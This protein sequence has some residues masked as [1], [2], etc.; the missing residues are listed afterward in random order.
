MSVFIKICGL[1]HRDALNAAVQAGADAVGF[2][3]AKS[4]RRVTPD[5]A[6]ELARDLP[7]TIIR[8]AVMHH[9]TPEQWQEVA[10]IFQPDW[11][12]TDAEDLASL[13]ISASVRTVPVF[14]DRAKLDESVLAA[15]EFIV[16]EAAVS[17]Q[18]TRADWQRARKLAAR[19]S[20][21]LAGGLDPENV[22]EAIEKVNPWGVDVS[23]GV[24]ISRGIKDLK[25][26]AAFIRAVRNVEQVNAS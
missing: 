3:F 9:P 17:G 22:A 6:A 10:D 24:E 23:S 15:Y 19:K 1:K 2:V 16:F 7:D 13:A 12:Q 25:K 14:R 11:L 26:I 4:P 5:K 21:M 18:G 8:V 20:L